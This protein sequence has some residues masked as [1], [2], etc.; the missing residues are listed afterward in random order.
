VPIDIAPEARVGLIALPRRCDELAQIFG[1]PD[2][3]LSKNGIN[4]P[5]AEN[6]P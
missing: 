6:R 5:M 1:R 3:L 4:R 2:D